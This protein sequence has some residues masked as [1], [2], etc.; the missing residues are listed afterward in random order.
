MRDETEELGRRV[1]RRKFEVKMPVDAEGYAGRTCPQCGLFFKVKA[2]TGRSEDHPQH[3][4]DCGCLAEQIHFLTRAQ[5]DYARAIASRMGDMADA[6]AVESLIA[7][8]LDSRIQRG[9]PR[10]D[11]D[12]MLRRKVRPAPMPKFRE[13]DIAEKYLCPNCLLRYAVATPPRMCP[14]CGEPAS[15]HPPHPPLPPHP[16]RPADPARPSDASDPTHSSDAADPTRSPDPARPAD[17]DSAKKSA[18][19]KHARKR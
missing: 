11:G 1:Y 12:A 16:V 10:G 7:G 15:S 4:P 8:V 13:P 9:M 3:C 2:G 19:K 17:A 6:G 18:G 5:M 14:D